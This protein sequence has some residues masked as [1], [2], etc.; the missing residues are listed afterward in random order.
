MN[1]KIVYK[2]GQPCPKCKDTN[3]CP[4]C[5]RI[6]AQGQATVVITT[7]ELTDKLQWLLD[8]KKAG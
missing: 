8:R 5:G 4:K 1:K 2:D 7:S 6:H 3:T